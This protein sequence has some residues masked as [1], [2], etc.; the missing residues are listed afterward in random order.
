MAHSETGL[1][2][3]ILKAAMLMFIQQGYHGL[4][5]RQIAEAVGVSKAALY[6]HFKDKEEL[7]LAMLISYLNEMEAELDRITSGTESCREK[8]LQFIHYVLSQPAERRAL[9]RLASQEM[10]QLSADARKTFNRVYRK[11]FIEKVEAI[12][13]AGIESGEI[14]SLRPEVATHTLL[15]IMYPYFYP[16]TD[17]AGL[18]AETIQQVI[19]VYLDGVS[20]K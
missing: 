3:E 12:L 2:E 6:Y 19:S 20:S 5:M 1:R 13:R 18:P 10:G 17:D 14:R 15:G 16:R 11:K 4:A 7:F 9:I 8:I